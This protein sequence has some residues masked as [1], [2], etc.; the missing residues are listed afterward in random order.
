MPDVP[1]FME[2][3]KAVSVPMQKPTKMLILLILELADSPMTAIE[4]RNSLRSRGVTPRLTDIKR[5]LDNLICSKN[6]QVQK[7]F[8]HTVF[9]WRY[10]KETSK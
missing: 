8:D 10:W 4:I 5:H 2:Q 6:L 9:K 7:E 1:Q 3:R